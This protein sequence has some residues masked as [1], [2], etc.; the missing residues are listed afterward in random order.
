MVNHTYKVESDHDGMSFPN[1]PR[2]T[3]EK[4]VQMKIDALI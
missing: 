2:I 3:H 1:F 4:Y